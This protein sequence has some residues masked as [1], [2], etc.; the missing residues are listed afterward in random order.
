MTYEQLS[1]N[2][3]KLVGKI[4]NKINLNDEMSVVFYG[5]KE[6]LQLAQATGI[7]LVT[8][9]NSDES[10]KDVAEAR[11]HHFSGVQQ[12]HKLKLL[13]MAAEQKLAVAQEEG[14]KALFKRLE[15]LANASGLEVN[16]HSVGFTQNYKLLEDRTEELRL[17][18]N[19]MANAVDRLQGIID[20][21]AEP[22]Q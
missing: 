10:Q 5:E 11:L 4:F 13:I 22:S 2:D 20:K 17:V 3:Q 21:V 14:K 8:I 1:R 6:R 7:A 19:G 16:I 15:N 9:A 12:M 18:F